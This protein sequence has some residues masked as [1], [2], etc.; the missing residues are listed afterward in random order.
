MDYIDLVSLLRAYNGSIQNVK[1]Y[2]KIVEKLDRPDNIDKGVVLESGG[3]FVRVQVFAV[4]LGYIDSYLR[5]YNYKTKDNIYMVNG[6]IITYVVKGNKKFPDWYTLEGTLRSGKRG[7]FDFMS[8]FKYRKDG[9]TWYLDGTRLLDIEPEDFDENGRC[10]VYLGDCRDTNNVSH[11]KEVYAL[12]RF[13]AVM[14]SIRAN[15]LAGSLDKYT[16]NVPA[17][18]PSTKFISKFKKENRDEIKEYSKVAKDLVDILKKSKSTRGSFISKL[19]I[20]YY[21]SD[22][23]TCYVKDIVDA[24]SCNFRHKPMNEAMTGRAIVKN[25]LSNFKGIDKNYLGRTVGEYILDIFD[26]ICC[27]IKW[28]DE[29]NID[30]DAWKVC[31]N[32]FGDPEMFYAGVIGVLLGVSHNKMMELY[33][34]CKSNELSFSTILNEN[35]YLLQVICDTNFTDIEYLATCLRLSDKAELKSFRNIALI[36]SYINDSTQSNTVFTV[37]MLER[38]NMGIKLTQAKYESLKATG[39]ILSKVVRANICSYIKNYVSDC[40]SSSNYTYDSSSRAYVL[41]L[42]KGEISQAIKDYVDVGLGIKFENYVTSCSLAEKELFVYQYLYDRG[43]TPTGYPNDL[44]DKYINEYEDLIGFKLEPEQRQAVHLIKYKAGIVAGSAGSGKTTTSNCV[45]YVLEKLDKVS[46]KFATPTGKA[47]KR[48]QEVVQRPVKTM[49]SMFKI[50]ATS[51][52]ILHNEDYSNQGDEIVYLFDENGMVT[53]DLLYSVLC[54]TGSDCSFYLFGDFNQLPPIGKGL[55]FKNLLRFLPCVFLTVSKRAA[56]GSNIT[57]VSDIINNYSN[58][59]NWRELPSGKDLFLIPCNED[60][61]KDYC[62][63]FVRHY[64]GNAT[65]EDNNLLNRSVGLSN[66]PVIDNLTPDDIQVVSPIGKATYTWGTLRMNTLLQPIFNTTRGYN[67]TYVNQKTEDGGYSKFVLNDRV[68]HTENMYSMQWYASYSNGHFDKRYGYGVC[69]GDVGK[70]VAFY[71]A[72]SCTFGN[73]IDIMPDDFEYPETLRDDSTFNGDRDYFVVVEYFDYMSDSN[74]YII[75]RAT[76]N[77]FRNNL[78]IS[79]KG[80]DLDKIQLFYAGTIHKLQGSQAKLV[81]NL[82]GSVNFSGFISRNMCYTGVTRAEKAEFFIGSVGNER[83]S[84]LS[85]AR[86]IVAGENIMTLGEIFYEEV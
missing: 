79:L 24:I 31:R 20:D 18:V 68:I 1:V 61:I 3:I 63:A 39:S 55:P 37:D 86:C 53:I 41:S 50:G 70:I 62:L 46:I 69:N 11:P 47:A 19:K 77:L 32:A 58:V 17:P 52:S 60:R 73:E 10:R 5:N 7:V 80:E 29:V 81:I 72:N 56:E 34:V 12:P 54:R 82:L 49:N 30:G 76:E 15:S 28:Q 22:Y 38:S 35:P 4:N 16:N 66:L 42:S 23:C 36:N 14:K 84:Q 51:S 26:E 13:D 33:S 71:P 45:V 75:Y 48:M 43:N 2:G 59:N 67:N 27:F 9:N 8:L 21:D 74:F 78:G 85:R 57:N 40:Y 6:D 25:Y 64:L 65:I 44:I 83:T